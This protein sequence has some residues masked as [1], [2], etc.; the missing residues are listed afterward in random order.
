MS[1]ILIGASEI[2][3]FQ[4]NGLGAD[5]ALT[6]VSV[7]LNDD[8]VTFANPL[9]P[10]LVGLSGF[11][12]SLGTPAVTYT[13]ESVETRTSLTLTSQYLA[14]TGT[15]TGT[16]HKLVFLR[17]YALT[18]FV[19]SGESFPV[20]AGSPGST[21]W[22]RRYGVSVISDGTQNVAHVPEITLPATTNSNVPTARYFA[23]LYTKGDSGGFIQAFPGCVDEWQLDADT[24]PTSW[25]QICDFNTPPPPTPNLNPDDFVTERELDARFPSGLA[26]QLLYFESTGDV[27]TPLTLGP[28]LQITAGVLEFAGPGGVNRIQ[29]EGAN[30]PQQTTLNFVGSSF[31]AADDAGNNRTNVTSDADLDALA[32][33]STNGFWART[34][35]GTGAARTLTGTANEIAV[36]NGDG[37]GVP[38]FSLPA[39]LTFTGKTITG[40]TYS[41]PT[42]NTPTVTTPTITGGT[43]TAITG[44]GVRSTGSGAFDLTLA[45]TENLT[46]GRTL[47]FTVNDAARTVSLAG[48]LTIAGAFITSGANSLTLTTT[49]ATNVTLPTTGTL[50]TLA[51]TETFTNKT[52]TSPRIGTSILDTNGNELALL[53][54]TG[55]AVNE[56]TLANAATAGAPSITASGGD[57]NINLNL[58]AKGT[59]KV[60]IPG[61]PFTIEVNTTATGNVGAGL[62]SLHSFSLPAASL[63]TDGDYVTAKYGGTFATNDADKRIQVTIDAQVAFNSGARDLDLGNWRIEMTVVRVS[64]TSV[65]VSGFAA[66][67]IVLSGTDGALDTGNSR[68]Y[69]QAFNATLTVANLTSNAVI[70][71]TQ[72][73]ATSNND[74]VQNAST[75]EL[76]QR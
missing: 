73:E 42:I 36:A 12:I 39:A 18:A 74:I 25:A 21:A 10:Y 44:L 43:H 8:T 3:G 35:A 59:G 9:P 14:T 11:K 20:Q 47:T 15:V 19:P 48:N 55:S 5:I 68:W 76:V 30:L 56:I 64:S 57:S 33:N 26:D 2:S 27:L 7:T 45:N 4:P 53:T 46:A 16:L 17:V 40:G 70:L 13:V 22:F 32:S 41:S 67:G 49:G 62:D 23:G 52:L 38:T 1:D 75:I 6:G 31:T 72:G 51:G 66:L 58:R 37:S 50:A 28:D 63:A 24:T 61:Y 71:L 34:G 60:S 54:A 29:E 69:Y 65:R